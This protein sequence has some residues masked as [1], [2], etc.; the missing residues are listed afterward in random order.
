MKSV[1]ISQHVLAGTSREPLKERNA[2][3]FAWGEPIF[4][5]S[6]GRRK[7]ISSSWNRRR[8]RSIAACAHLCSHFTRIL[9][10]FN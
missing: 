6:G 10:R 7:K 1:E 5:R 8:E 4:G 3:G 9:I 2:R